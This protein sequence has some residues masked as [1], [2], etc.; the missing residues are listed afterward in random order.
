MQS[1]LT[2]QLRLDKLRYRII[3]D[4]R[5]LLE[6]KTLILVVALIRESN[7]RVIVEQALR[8]LGL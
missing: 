6:S 3:R 8:I 5:T 1:D 2:P 4:I 7:L